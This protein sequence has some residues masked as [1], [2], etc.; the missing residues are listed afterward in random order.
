[1]RVMGV[2]DPL[3]RIT[4]ILFGLLMV[5]TFTGTLS[6]ATGGHEE[7]RSVL[8]AAMTIALGG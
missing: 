1:M 2:L 5:L 6:V 4:G 3:D 8:V 7:V